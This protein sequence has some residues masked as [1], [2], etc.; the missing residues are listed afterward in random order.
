METILQDLRF[1]AR[2]LWKH[3]AFTLTAILTLALGIGAN[4]AIF[5]VV[6]SVLLA[7]LPYVDANRIVALDTYWTDKGTMS[8]RVT[9]P[10]A[11][12]VRSEAHSLNAV[13][14][15]D[16]GDNEGVQ[17]RDHSVFTVV[18][19]VD[20]NFARV[21]G[22]V[23]LAGRVFTNAEA[24]RAALVSERFAQDNF[25]EAEAALGQTVRFE[26]MPLQITGVLPPS[27]DFPNKSQVWVAYPFLPESEN[28]TAFNY[29]AV[30]KLRAGVS[31]E[32][33]QAEL[34]AISARL[35]KAYPNDNK[36][37]QMVIAPLQEE[38]TGKVRP[39]LMLLFAAVATI[40]LIACVNVAHLVLARS[41]ERQRE[42]AVRTALGSSR[43]Q[44]GRLVLAE[45][46][47]V[48]LAGGALGALVAAPAVRLLLA[49]AP[50]DL[51]RAA[52]IHLNSWVLA[53]TFVLSL[54][55][56]VVSSVLPA[57]RAAKI[58]PAEA[59]KQDS[60]RGMTGQS[61]TAMR[62][63]LVVA[64]VAA[65]FALAVAAGLL[66]RTLMT[67]IARDLGYQT[68]QILVVDADA[69]AHDINDAQ[70]VVRDYDRLFAQLRALPGV[71]SVA[72]IM[73]LPTAARGSNGYY[74]V[75]GKGAVDVNHSP[76]ADFSVISPGYFETL[77][78]RLLRG[79]DFNPEDTYDT[80]FV[81]II[82]ESV[83]KA[84]FGDDDP[85]G[86]Q[87]Q[88]GLDSDKWM[89]IVGVVTDVRQDSPAANPGA[90]LYMPMAQH[91]LFATEIHIVLRT[92][93]APLT[94]MH[95]VQSNI[96]GVNPQIATHFTTMDAMVS[97]S[98]AAERFRTAL[99]SSF[100]GVALLLAMLG[101][102]GTMAYS[103]A[104]RRFE[105]GVRMAFGAE[106]TAI[107]RMVLW[108]AA[109]LACWGI[110][111]G[112]TLSLL[113]T[114][115]VTSMLVGVRAID[116]ISIAIAAALMMLTAAAAA[117]APAWRAA[118]VDPMIALRAE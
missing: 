118:Q 106:K 59:L 9:G 63:F 86:K 112:L 81:A 55:T 78:I 67:L 33:A 24:G 72:G 10:D 48:S 30:A 52:E 73:G 64:E 93:V 75:T 91:P 104:Q 39:M 74:T 90:T 70:H 21:F 1:A 71:Q 26:N 28:R 116:P 7:P 111:L 102:Y 16:Y 50:A 103:V 105:I 18:T 62:N 95:A 53:F 113:L 19:G 41:I 11:T 110:A 100:A 89:T 109:K 83:A 13:S 35:E 17:L 88:C 99:I 32:T 58:D 49:M 36:R 68:A 2:Q 8:H 114:R 23:P 92:L 108:H 77:G 57:R 51:P 97:R 20:T 87:V 46:L 56:T 38:L 98:I 3:P 94:L 4:T 44:L 40:L 107:L 37:K 42:L 115:L 65:T 101:V 84:N 34:N 15:Y 45:S 29:K 47:L 117:L 6:E 79:R 61:A 60:S 43:W 66:L 54:A 96:S 12:D 25:G 82:S 27:F 80:Q 31:V 14:L 85:I 76:Y 69:P 5:T 22:L